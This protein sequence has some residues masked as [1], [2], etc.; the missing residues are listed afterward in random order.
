MD[1][2]RGVGGIE[3]VYTKNFDA[4]YFDSVCVDNFQFEVG[5][6]DYGMEIDGINGFDSSRGGE[7]W[8]Y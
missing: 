1:S 2:I 5:S 6:M 3:Y 4:I 7:L 8:I